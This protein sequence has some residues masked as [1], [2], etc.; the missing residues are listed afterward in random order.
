VARRHHLS[1][2]LRRTQSSKSRRVRA[3]GD[4]ALLSIIAARC[5]A[6]DCGDSAGHDSGDSESAPYGYVLDIPRHPLHLCACGWNR[7]DGCGSDAPVRVE[8]AFRESS[9][10]LEYELRR[11]NYDIAGTVFRPAIAALTSLVPATQ[12]LFGSDS[13]V[14]DARRNPDEHRHLAANSKEHRFEVKCLIASDLVHLAMRRY[15]RPESFS[16]ACSFSHSDLRLRFMAGTRVQGPR[17]VGCSREPAVAR[18]KWQTAWRRL[19]SPCSRNEPSRWTAE[20]SV[21]PPAHP[22]RPTALHSRS[23]DEVVRGPDDTF[24]LE[25]P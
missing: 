18:P 5:C 10:R 3:S 2:R 11:L 24:P 25:V 21:A 13:P 9:Q 22:V 23:L 16:K 8:N 17:H 14:S 7:A 12:I 20:A 6:D 4:G 1:S 19:R 15:A